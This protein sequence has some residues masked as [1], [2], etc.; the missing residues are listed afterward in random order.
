MPLSQPP[1]VW[2]EAQPGP[3]DVGDHTGGLLG[4]A[5]TPTLSSSLSL[6]TGMPLCLSSPQGRGI[7]RFCVGQSKVT[8]LPA[9]LIQNRGFFYPVTWALS[10]GAMNEPCFSGPLGGRE[11]GVHVV[12]SGPLEDGLL[13][14][15]PIG[16]P[17][18]Q[19]GRLRRSMA[20]S[21]T[22]GSRR[23]S[24]YTRSLPCESV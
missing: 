7:N 4:L 1:L 15:Q 5:A 24:L 21:T 9:M 11:S 20:K 12:P 8:N 17:A 23:G 3:G 13:S 10:S 6:C 14:Q 2:G 19:I 22:Q 16:F 18:S